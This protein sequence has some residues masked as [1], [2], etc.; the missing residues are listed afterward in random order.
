MPRFIITNLTNLGEVSTL[1][2]VQDHLLAD[3][4]SET[5]A[6]SQCWID[7]LLSLSFHRL[8]AQDPDRHQDTLGRQTT[9][10]SYLETYIDISSHHLNEVDWRNSFPDMKGRHVP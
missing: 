3:D 6:H 10:T 4:I 9:R 8:H 1:K 5:G 2:L 7:M